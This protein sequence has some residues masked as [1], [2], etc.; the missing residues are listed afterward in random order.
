VF[1][2]AIALW[3]WVGA[4]DAELQSERRGS[5]TG[6]SNDIAPSKG[7]FSLTTAL[8][9]PAT[10]TLR[11]KTSRATG[12]GWVFKGDASVTETSC[13]GKVNAGGK[14][15]LVLSIQMKFNGRWKGIGG[16]WEDIS[17]SAKCEGDLTGTVAS[18]GTWK[19][20]CKSE[21]AEWETS[22]DWKFD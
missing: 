12:N 9:K 5:W 11:G 6:F 13:E 16:D 18:G 17:G 15:A 10:C 22:I 7:T 4:D 3:A 14:V 21:N 20:T 1:A 19:G 8:G 2:A